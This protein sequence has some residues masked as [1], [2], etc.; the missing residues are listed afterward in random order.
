MEIKE[1][2]NKLIFKLIDNLNNYENNL[3]ELIKQKECFLQQ[4]LGFNEFESNNQTHETIK[5]YSAFL[6]KKFLK[7]GKIEKINIV[8]FETKYNDFRF[9]KCHRQCNVILIGGWE[10]KEKIKLLLNENIS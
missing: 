6:L 9:G 7:D 2:S 5:F 1:Q 3:F 4:D 8:D 10:R